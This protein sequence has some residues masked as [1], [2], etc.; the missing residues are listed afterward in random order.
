[1]EHNKEDYLSPH[2]DGF[3]KIWWAIAILLFL[4]LLFMWILGYG[5][6][7]KQCQVEPEIKTV[8]K[9]VAA[10][11][12][13]APLITLNGAPVLHL[14][15]GDA[16]EESG[17]R[18]VDGVD[19]KLS[20][21]AMGE[22]DTS[23][24]GEYLV[25]Y[26]VTDA[27]GNT[28]TE[29]RKVLVS[30]AEDTTKPVLTLGGESIVHLK[31]GERYV[32]S[33]ATAVDDRDGDL[34]VT[35]DGFVDAGNAGEYVI[36]YS[37]VDDAGN[38]ASITRKVVVIDPDKSAP[39]ISL[40][41]ASV[42]YLKTGEQ[43]QEPGAKAVD[44][45]DGELTI[46][47]EGEV[48]TSKA[49]EYIVTYKVTDSAGNVASKTR[50]VV[51]AAADDRGPVISLNQDPV[52]YLERGNDY[53]EAGAK[54]VDAVDGEVEVTVTGSV[55]TSKVG[56]HYVTYTARDKAGNVSTATR[57]VLVS[58][59][60]QTG[61]KKATIPAA[62][63]EDKAFV[64]PSAKLYFGRDK[65][66]NPTD[67]TNALAAVISYL[68]AHQEAG[69]SVAGY[70]DATGHAAYNKD[71]AQ[72]RSK[73]VISQLTSAG[74]STERI[75]LEKPVETTGTGTPAEARRVEVTVGQ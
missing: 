1:M 44:A 29:V 47:T 59:A 6:G 37:A 22:V 52:V 32:E 51:V 49:G 67:E 3:R 66:D 64:I 9:L 68:K 70:H 45:K 11:D 55:D 7:G 74:I 33:G 42:I 69:V 2:W 58:Q 65:D 20:V 21:K 16:Y 38:K 40:N 53:T 12:V 43:Y 10:P 13:S 48:D 73:T 34:V 57:K 35:N 17:A 8:E 31:T 14:S 75:T 27:A 25:T 39:I 30:E 72:R 24:V 50:R 54:A 62:P 15:Q 19:G 56:D 28:A 18:A 71:L 63:V 41:D 60:V 4:I 23:K 46:T 61:F 36:T 26:E 5:P